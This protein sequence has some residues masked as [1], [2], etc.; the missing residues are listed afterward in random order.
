MSS[1]AAERFT[2][3]MNEV[4][5][6]AETMGDE[7]RIETF[8]VSADRLVRKVLRREGTVVETDLGPS[9]ADVGVDD[10]LHALAD[11][12]FIRSTSA[13]KWASGNSPLAIADL[14][15]GV[16]SLSLGVLEAARAVGMSARIV[17]AADDDP[18][19]LRVLASSLDPAPTAT[20][21]IDLGSTLSGEGDEATPAERAFLNGCPE[22]IDVLV[23]GPP[24]QG[25]SRLNNHTRHDDPRNDLY[26]C[27]VRFVELQR[28]RLCIIE[29]VDSIVADRRRSAATVVNALS[30]MSYDVTSGTVALN[31][32]GVA[33]TRRRHVVVATRADQTK[34]DVEWVTQAL[35]VER[36]EGR[37][38]RW[39]IEDLV[40]EAPE[41]LL[42]QPTKPSE[43]NARRM[44]W[45][46]QN[47]ETCDLPDD[48]RPA[49]HRLPKTLPSG[50]KRTHS[51]KSMYGRLGW[52]EPAQT[53]TSGYGSMG[54]G[55][56]VHPAEARTVTPH[57]AARLQL[58][59]DFFD[60]EK[61]SGRGRWARMIGNA[62]P[63]KLSYVL[64]LEFLR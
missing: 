10:D 32:L 1:L 5:P 21:C 49:C 24:C 55:R 27:V 6:I 52:D 8:A 20:R 37:T 50:E 36:P 53:L 17:L 14:F 48:Q 47:P 31:R 35:A 29:N 51:Y 25:H 18:N 34:V 9:P 42:D 13:P 19:P 61:V 33:Q 43:E 39:A 56:Y 7:Q 54:Q 16:G 30:A 22:Q 60:F 58:L 59:P 46:H 15:S 38:V 57:E 28:P 45:L 2:T 64:A 23:A 26:G 62:A 63:L 12:A 44:T 4:Q 11:Q 40:H 3:S 41:R